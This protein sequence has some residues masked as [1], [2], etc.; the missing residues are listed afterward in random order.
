[1]DSD[2]S[3]IAS[4]PVRVPQRV[5]L[6]DFFNS[7]FSSGQRSQVESTDETVISETEARDVTSRSVQNNQSLDTSSSVSSDESSLL[8]PQQLNFDSELLGEPIKPI[9]TN[10][11]LSSP[12]QEPTLLFRGPK[13]ALSAFY[14]HPLRWRNH[15]YLSAEVAYQHEMFSHHKLP[16][17]A[18]RELLRSRSSHE[19]KR[20]ASKWVPLCSD[21]W[22]DI[23]FTV[24]EEICTMKLKQC[25]AFRTALYESGTKRLLHNTETDP[26]W[27]CGPDLLGKNMMGRILMTVRDQAIQLQRECPPSNSILPPPPKPNQ[28]QP[29]EPSPE[30]PTLKARKP[31]V[32]VI[33]NSNVRGVARGLMERDVD[34]TAFVYPGQVVSQIKDRIDNIQETVVNFKPDAIL[35]HAGDIEVRDRSISIL[36]IIEDVKGLIAH[37]Q[38][39]FGSKVVVSGLPHVP[40]NSSLNQRIKDV[41]N[42]LSRL[43]CDSRSVT[44]I[45]NERAKLQRDQIHLTAQS[46][47]LLCRATA[48]HVKCC[49]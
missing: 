32:L 22:K 19:A 20:T 10:R 31:N 38:T 35:L 3:V 41:N 43:S 12:D 45:S 37:V 25:R 13:N 39:K 24:M 16:P 21:S 49:V 4:T 8:L 29:E 15:T 5:R 48:Q 47:D 44:F 6:R 23:R 9:V 7:L 42:A 46:K 2:T 33:G 36:R 30:E 34:C 14:H 11:N 1:M 27:G 18:H 17:R 40:Q 26:I 28:P